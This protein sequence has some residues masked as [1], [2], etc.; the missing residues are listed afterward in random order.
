MSNSHA[1][2]RPTRSHREDYKAF[3]TVPTRWADNDVYGH[4][5]NV[6]Y[7]E[8]FDTA[9]NGW[10]LQQGALDVGTSLIIGIVAETSCTYFESV[11]FP[12]P[13]EIG[14]AIVHV[15]RSSATYAIGVFKP[16]IAQAIAQG[17]FTHVHVD[18]LTRRPVPIPKAT[19]ALMQAI[20]ITA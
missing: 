1:S 10:L 2:G 8:W 16:G 7:Y 3:C 15:G 13:V 9:V 12:D 18:S 4:V 14:I 5:N 11:S 20:Q 6:V 17:R 19:R